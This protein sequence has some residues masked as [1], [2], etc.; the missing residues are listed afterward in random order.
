MIPASVPAALAAFRA[1]VAANAPVASATPYQIATLV[2]Q[3]QALL[4]MIDD[5]LAAAGAQLDAADPTGHPLQMIADLTGRLTA[6][7][8]QE[9]LSD[10]RGFVGR[11]VFNLAQAVA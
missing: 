6:V 5:A 9:T 11:A 3:G 7:S 2:S 10:M 1:A 8:D 4:A